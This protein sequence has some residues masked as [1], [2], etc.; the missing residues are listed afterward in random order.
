MVCK[1]E[2]HPRRLV[3]ELSVVACG[4]SFA[5]DDSRF[6]SSACS[7]EVCVFLLEVAVYSHR[8]TRE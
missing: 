1:S 8:R 7:S 5:Q 3:V 2:S 6:R 4:K